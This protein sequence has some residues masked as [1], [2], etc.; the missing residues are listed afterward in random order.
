MT[1]RNI[2]T[3]VAM[4][5]LSA[6]G[7]RAATDSGSN[8]F[9]ELK[10]YQ[11]HNSPENQSERLTEFLR[12]GYAPAVARAGGKL[13]GAFGNYIGLEGPYLVALTQYDSLAV[14]ESVTTKLASDS[15]YQ[16]A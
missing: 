3:G 12:D 14:K 13:V 4:S 10:T 8:V 1:R 15:D 11:L 16:N 2:L 9:L 6:S 7:S 5:A